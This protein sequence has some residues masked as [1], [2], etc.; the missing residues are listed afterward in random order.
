LSFRTKQERT[1]RNRVLKI[2]NKLLTEESKTFSVERPKGI[3]L[4][5]SLNQLDSNSWESFSEKLHIESGKFVSVKHEGKTFDVVLIETD[6][7]ESIGEFVRAF[8]NA[9]K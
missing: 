4:V 3:V 7:P 9:S 6:N 5:T 8:I 1:F 2:F